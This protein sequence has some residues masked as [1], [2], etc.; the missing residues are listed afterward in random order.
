MCNTVR[1]I[2]RLPQGI[3]R[4]SQWSSHGCPCAL[5]NHQHNVR[6]SRHVTCDAV[7]GVNV[8]DPVRKVAQ[9]T[10]LVLSP[11]DTPSC[12][13]VVGDWTRIK[14]GPIVINKYHRMY[15]T[16]KD[17]KTFNLFCPNLNNS[18]FF[19]TWTRR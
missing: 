1:R 4:A 8:Y 15:L 11:V 6:L 5:T 10:A 16:C 17:W 18:L 14:E 3:S 12:L 2:S 13:L 7:E 19:C 9:Y